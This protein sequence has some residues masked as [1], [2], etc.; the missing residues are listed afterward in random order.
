[1][2]LLSGFGCWSQ[3]QTTALLGKTNEGKGSQD[4]T[5]ALLGKTN[6]GREGRPNNGS[7]GEDQQGRKTTALL[8][9]TNEGGSFY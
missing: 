3:D 2:D 5:T 9:N 1:M 6:E 7:A 8:G 4:Q